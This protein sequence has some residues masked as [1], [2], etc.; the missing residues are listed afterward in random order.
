DDLEEDVHR[1]TQVEPRADETPVDFR[2]FAE[3]TCDCSADDMGHR[4][5]HPGALAQPGDVGEHRPRVDRQAAEN[6]RILRRMPRRGR[7]A[8]PRR[9]VDSFE[10][11]HGVRFCYTSCLRCESASS[12]TPCERNGRR[13]PR[14]I[15]RGKPIAAATRYSSPASIRSAMATTIMCSPKR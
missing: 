8:P 6:R 10:T 15:W 7:D 2:A 3:C 4:D 11:R 5:T 9:C 13:T 14:C 1:V 12:S